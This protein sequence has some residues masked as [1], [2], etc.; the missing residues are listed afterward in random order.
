MTDVS[1]T[2]HAGSLVGAGEVTVD[3]TLRN[4]G[5][6]RMAVEPEVAVGGAFGLLRERVDGDR[7]DELLPGGEVRR[8]TTVPG[9]WPLVL[10]TVTVDATAVAP[11]AGDDP[12]VGTVVGAVR[13]WAVPGCVVA[14]PG[15]RH[16]RA[17]VRGRSVAGRSFPTAANPGCRGRPS[18]GGAMTAPHVVPGRPTAPVVHPGSILVGCAA[19][20]VK[21]A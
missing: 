12:G 11:A 18:R 5:N 6:V 10:E 21:P 9:V 2:W 14:P 15:A 16:P 13:V 20:D 3:Y 7:V 8:S 19:R 4:T 17:V 1:A